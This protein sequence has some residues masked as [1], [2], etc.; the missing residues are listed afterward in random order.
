MKPPIY[1]LG[2][3]IVLTVG[4]TGGAAALAVGA[5]GAVVT[6]PFFAAKIAI[7]YCKVR[8][9]R[10]RLLALQRSF[11]SRANITQGVGITFVGASEMFEAHVE[12]MEG[13]VVLPKGSEVLK[14]S[15]TLC[16]AG[17][18]EGETVDGRTR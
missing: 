13:R 11:A 12:R 16:T 3:P 4:V 17:P 6:A 7:K 2:G 1:L 9:E 18:L 5:T 8:S 15:T 10:R 14:Q